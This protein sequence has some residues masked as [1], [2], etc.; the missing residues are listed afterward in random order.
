MFRNRS[1]RALAS[2]LLAVSL[3]LSA[4][5]GPAMILAAQPTAD[6]TATAVPGAV[7]P[8][9]KVAFDI[10]FKNTSPSNLAQFFLNA[11]TPD[12]ATLV[13]VESSTRPGCDTSS[14]DLHCTFGAVNS[15]AVVDLRVVYTT[16]SAKGTFTVPFKFSTTG[17]APDKGKNSH[18]DDYPTSGSATL[19]DSKDFAGAYTSSTGQVVSDSQDLHRTRNPQFTKVTA[20]EGAIGVTVGE[21]PGSAFICPPSAG[22]CFGQWSLISVNDSFNYGSLGQAFSVQLGYKGNIGNA[23]FVHVHNDGTIDLITNT[24]P[25]SPPPFTSVPC[26]IITTSGGDSFVTLWVKQNGRASGY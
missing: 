22:T 6:H 19:D 1:T 24:C 26:K 4:L 17:V 20:P 3:A 8:G 7:T 15:Q 25:S 11:D 9:A 12:G 14:G 21:A 18:G 13:E 16:P 23:N 2:L 5:A 10:H